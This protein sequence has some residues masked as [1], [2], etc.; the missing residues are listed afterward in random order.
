MPNTINKVE[1]GGRTL[2]DLTSDTVTA[3]HLESGYT[4]HDASGNVITGTLNPSGISSAVV[5]T[6]ETD[7]GGGIIKHINAVDI[8]HDTVTA[9]HLEIGYTSHDS[10]GNAIIGTLSPSSSPTLQNKSVTPTTST[11][12][13]T[14]DSGYDGLDT[15]TVNPIPSQ[16][17][18]PTGS[19]EITSN[20][21]VDVT[22]YATAVVNVQASGSS[23][24]VQI[25]A[26]VNRA[27]SSTYT[28]ISGQSLTVA[29]TGK[30][31]IYWSGYRSSTSGTSGS[32]LYINNTAYGSAQ[33]AFTN[34]GQSIH[35][36]NVSLTQGQTIS[37]RARSR[38]SNYYMYVGNLTIIQSS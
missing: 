7:S 36:S 18:I 28:E 31:D 30:Y 37:I 23:K 1:Y 3:G 2:I 38:G 11:Q 6:E 17:I 8:S 22:Q 10:S 25:A 20:T 32:Q 13:V 14:A 16:Y 12:S 15:V 4:A 27:T 35:L 19:I 26:G 34:H 29:V 21:T 24:N 9:A 5:V 33:T